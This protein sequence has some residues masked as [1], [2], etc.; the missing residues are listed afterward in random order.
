[1]NSKC[2]SLVIPT[3]QRR[4]SVKRLL[5]A[6]EAQTF[7][8]DS[9]EVLVAIDGSTDGTEELV[10][11][12]KTPYCLRSFYQSN[13]GRAAACNI[14]IRNAKGDL[15]VLL[16]DDMEP[17]P[18]FLAAHWRAHLENE[19]L[20]V[21]GAAP[22]RI[23]AGSSS[24]SDYIAEKFRNHLEKLSQPGYQL[25]LRDF[26]SGNFSIRSELFMEAG[27]FDEEFRLY[28]N[29]DL[30]LSLRLRKAGISLIFCKDALAYQYY[31]KDFSALARDNIQ[32]GKTAVLFV[33]KHPEVLSDLKI[34][35]YNEASPRWAFLRALLLRLSKVWSRTPQIVIRFITLL[36]GIRPARLHF[37]YQLA[38][39]Y[40][41]WLGVKNEQ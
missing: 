36:E 18:E 33:K 28:G 11:R 35:T 8:P 16:D 27:L 4:D 37:Y 13:C 17:A 26:Y 20:G 22:V 19:K 23:R 38:L 3:Y 34:G 6:L 1:V 41:F 12:T 7:Q 14:G 15:I 29:E 5:N 21:V 31:E 24:V 30:E 2:I 9:F 10:A 32:K 40:F 39:D 25:N